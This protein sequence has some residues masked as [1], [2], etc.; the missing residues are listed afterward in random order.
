MK[1]ITLGLIVC[2]LVFLLAGCRGN[3]IAGTYMN[4]SND[5]SIHII[6]DST[7]EVKQ[8]STIITGNY[9]VID[10]TSYRFYTDEV[11][12]VTNTETGE[13]IPAVAFNAVLEKDQLKV[14][15]H[16]EALGIRSMTDMPFAKQ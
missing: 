3:G 4:K 6:D 10:E 11:S 8:G 9:E 2:L 15:G 14:S 1:K 12:K 13:A 16:M 5:I 7:F